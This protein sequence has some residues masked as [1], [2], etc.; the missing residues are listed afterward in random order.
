MLEAI[1]DDS[2]TLDVKGTTWD[3]RQTVTLFD[4]NTYV[5]YIDNTVNLCAT[6]SHFYRYF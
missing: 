4:H 5:H 3:N 1:S 6:D 2:L